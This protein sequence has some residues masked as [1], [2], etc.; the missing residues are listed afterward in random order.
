MRT[1]S[2]HS[3]LLSLT[4]LVFA[5][6]LALVPACRNAKP[7]EEPVDTL[8]TDPE[9]TR[10]LPLT[11]PDT[12]TPEACVRSY[13][14]WVSHAYRVTNSAKAAATFDGYEEVR[15]DSYVQ[16][17]MQQSRGI[18]RR[19]EALDIRSSSSKGTTATIAAKEQW[20]YRYFNL[21]TRKYSTPVYFASYDS[22]YTL[23]RQRD[24]GWLVHRVEADP[25]GEVK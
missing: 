17:N 16:Y 8:A 25:I 22:T 15:V 13:L 12:R 23:V 20:R 3:P 9:P 19:L 5:F 14:D 6:A 1:S 7:V 4:V 21:A 24:G 18:D 10:N 2:S 11:E